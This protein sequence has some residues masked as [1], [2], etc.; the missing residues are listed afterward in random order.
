MWKN[1]ATGGEE[2]W[3]VVAREPFSADDAELAANAY[4]VSRGLGIPG[5]DPLTG[6]PDRRLFERRLDRADLGTRAKSR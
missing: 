3:I 5:H 1:F 6:L 2:H 4:A